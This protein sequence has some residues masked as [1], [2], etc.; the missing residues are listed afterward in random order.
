MAL[1]RGK[2]LVRW[3]P[4]TAVLAALL[5]FS[6]G[7]FQISRLSWWDAASILLLIGAL[8][9]SVSDRVRRR[10]TL[11]ALPLRRD[12][13]MGGT[14]VALAFVVVGLGG[15]HLYPL[16]YLVMAFLVSS[17]RQRTGPFLLGLA[18]VF[19]GGLDFFHGAS[20]V[21]VWGTHILFLALFTFL[22]HLVLSARLAQAHVAENEAVRNR[23]REAEE[24]ART[25]RLA[26]SGT[27]DSFSGIEEQEKWL[28]ASIKEIEGAVGAC[29]ELAET[30]LKTQTAAA[31]LLN[32]DERYLKL[33]DCRSSSERIQTEK[34]LS[35]EGVLGGSLK[36]NMPIRMNSSSALKGITYYQPGGPLVHSVLAVPLIETG[37][38]IR[39][40]VVADRAGN[41][42]FTDDDERL[43]ALVAGE[44]LRAIEVE[45]VMGYIRKNR[46]EKDR[47]Y[48]AIGELNRAGSP[49]QV[50]TAVLESAQQLGGLDF[51]GV[52]LV[53]EE[54]G[55]RYHRVARIV[56]AG[57]NGGGLENKTFVD[58]NGLV[59]NVVR[60]GTPL[61][62]REITAMEKQ[63]IFDG[64]TQIRGLAALKI[65]PLNAGDRILGTLVAG[66]RRKAALDTDVLRMLEVLAIQ[67]A[68]AVL[69]AQLFEQMEKMATTDGLT[70]L[71]NHRTFQSRAEEAFAHS[72][73]YGRKCSLLLTDIDHF[74]T[75]NDTHG[76]PMGDTVLRGVARILKEKARD[77]DTVARYGGE[78]FAIIMP[79]T[80]TKGARVIAERIREAIKAEVFQTEQGPLK[81]TMSLGISTCPDHSDDKQA[82]ID[83]ADGCLYHA[84]RHGRDQSVTVSEV[85]G[86]KMTA[87]EAKST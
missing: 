76:H 37:G 20:R 64:E 79:E 56:G 54:N 86:W 10:S 61:P 55:K 75:V 45:R 33:Y 48:K 32:D 65:F 23:I 59:A 21:S 6:L 81:V 84:K 77:T 66:S 11:S 71:Y 70:G 17:L 69:R 78:E 25:F 30:A 72:K 34:F 49:D 3:L 46:D 36:R 40:A 68:Q 13:E 67:A 8:S 26:S 24:R 38:L 57:T 47:F 39:G 27:Q 52:T 14:L 51:A 43:L 31:F 29:L 62:G 82:M 2:A 28:L 50:F 19:N 22:Y 44:V 4:A 58:N 42:P 16:I 80:D 1:S 87:L 53:S 41:L 85:R 12:V 60:Y 63:I 15:P 73:R 9:L 35:G 18:L 5:R 83:L 74:K 7:G